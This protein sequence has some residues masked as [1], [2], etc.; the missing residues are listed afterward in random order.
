[1][2]LRA[3]LFSLALL[4]VFACNE[5]KKDDKKDKSASG[6]VSP[7]PGGKPGQPGSGVMKFADAI[8]VLRDEMRAGAFRREVPTG[9]RESFACDESS[10]GAFGECFASTRR[11]LDKELVAPIDFLKWDNAGPNIVANFEQKMF[12]TCLLAVGVDTHVEKDKNG[13]AKNGIYDISTKTL[14]LDQVVQSCGSTKATIQ[15][16]IDTVPFSF[17][18]EIADAQDKV[19]YDKRFI[20][21]AGDAVATHLDILARYKDENVNFVVRQRYKNK[22]L[23]GGDGYNSM[24]RAVVQWN[25]KTD[26][27]RYEFISPKPMKVG[28]TG[29]AGTVSLRYFADGRSDIAYGL[30]DHDFAPR[31]T[32]TLAG[33]PV[34][35]AEI[36]LSILGGYLTDF[37][38]TS[39]KYGCL[40]KDLVAPVTTKDGSLAC[41]LAGTKANSSRLQSL[42][43]TVH[44]LALTADNIQDALLP[45]TSTLNLAFTGDDFYTA[46][47]QK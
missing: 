8:D 16:M 15:Y 39:V 35:G 23:Y 9:Y 37:N 30:A 21:D 2:K 13:Y 4:G 24:D 38:F 43:T 29:N 25:G 32:Y 33:K 40:Q 20:V 47:F 34:A 36:A 11:F 3:A 46:D 19:Q 6:D 17:N 12:L 27:L 45:L 41:Q 18:V 7:L 31:L 5:E 44:M 28:G 1:M 42:L 22:D 10:E 26:L 14:N